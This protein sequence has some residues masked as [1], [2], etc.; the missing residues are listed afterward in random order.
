MLPPVTRALQATPLGA[1][2]TVTF[3]CSL[4]TG[5]LWHG[6]PFIAKHTYG[7]SQERN[8]VLAAAMGAVYTA[9][10]FTAGGLTRWVERRLTP[11]DVLAVSIGILALVSLLPIFFAGVWSLWVAAL[12]GTYVTSL[13][14]P[15]IESYLTA[16]RH[17]ADMRRAIGLFN[18][19]WAPAVALPLFA[20]AP[21]LER[22]GQWAIGAIAVVAGIALVVA[23]SFTP[24]PGHHDAQVAGAHV[25]REYPLLLRSARVLLPLSYVLN[26]AMNPLLPY[27]FEELSVEVWWETPAAATWT[28]VRVLAFLLMSR[29][30]FWHGRWGSLLLGAALMTGGFAL[31]V[32]GPTLALVLAGL[33]ALGFGLGVIYYATLYYAMAVGRAAVEAGGN[34][35]GLI[36]AGYTVGPVGGLIGA[37]LGGAF[38]IVAVA[39]GLVGLAAMPAVRPYLLARRQ[40]S[41]LQR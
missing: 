18:L 20:M 9:G 24:Q 14:W 11:R 35:E 21:I 19:T 27:R 10:A 15:I 13:I 36:G 25:G 7:F 12:V 17:G 5:V 4:G 6:V 40:R 26:A 16:G 34:F 33:A 22:H 2:L 29:L 32:A 31:I 1:V 39:W 23:R 37:R 41:G 30:G 28:I 38:G 3:L 8:L